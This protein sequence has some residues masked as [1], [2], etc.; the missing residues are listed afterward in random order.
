VEALAIAQ[1]SLAE[2]VPCGAADDFVRG[3]A[4]DVD[5]GVGRVEDVCCVGEVCS[6][7]STRTAD[8]LKGRTVNGD[9]GDFHGREMH[10]GK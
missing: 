10:R 4:Q 9:E 3:V 5:D 7:V 8:G 2:E 1:F 6:T